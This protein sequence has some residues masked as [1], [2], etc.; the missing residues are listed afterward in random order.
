MRETEDA[1]NQRRLRV[2]ARNALRIGRLA[3]LSQALVRAGGGGSH[4]RTQ[5]ADIVAFC[6]SIV[7]SFEELAER[8]G[9]TLE[10]VARRSNCVGEFDTEQLGIIV[11]NLISNAL[12]ATPAG[13]RVG[14]AV[15][16]PES[17]LSIV[18]VDDGPGISSDGQD[19]LFEPRAARPPEVDGGV[20][21]AVSRSIVQAQ[22]GDLTVSSEEGRGARLELT[23]PLPPDRSRT[24]P[25]P[26]GTGPVP[27]LQSGDPALRR[28]TEHYR[29]EPVTPALPIVLVADQHRDFAEWLASELDDRVV[30]QVVTDGEEAL[31]LA[32]V[33]LPDLVIADKALAGI[34]GLS[35]CSRL[36]ADQRTSHVPVLVLT[37]GADSRTRIE[38]TRA[39]ADGQLPKPLTGDELRARVFTL[40]DRYESLRKSFAGSDTSPAQR[41]ARPIDRAFID[42]VYAVVD[43]EMT[44]SGFSVPDLADTLAMSTS[45]LTR[46]L[47]AVI[48]QT[49]AQLIRLRRL[50]RAAEL[51][52]GSPG[53]IA[54]VCHAVGFSDQSHFSRVFKRH[55]GHS[56]LEY[57]QTAPVS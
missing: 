13:G 4:S 5:L 46:K 34:D 38:V 51:I 27:A 44:D 8:R 32:T 53:N 52:V 31:R 10:F 16:F 19:A 2:V 56:P 57:R 3:E 39:G 35:L 20:T 12:Q 24:V 14:V 43:S 7:M 17:F 18:V 23:L 40:L 49:P 22:G 37:A 54:Q 48:D 9:T 41:A 21:L 26:P 15:E 1:E 36:R 29:P 45:Q 11:S 6:E 47:R 42:K 25:H 28:T 55:F 50:Q 30:A 33:Q